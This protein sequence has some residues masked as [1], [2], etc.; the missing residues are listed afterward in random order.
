[1]SKRQVQPSRRLVSG[2]MLTVMVAIGAIPVTASAGV[3]F[4]WDPAGA[5]VPL[6]G[7]GSK[8]TANGIEGGHYLWSRQPQTTISPQTPYTVDFIEQITQ[9]TLNGVPVATPGLNGTPGAAG[10]YGL[11]LAMQAN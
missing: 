6:G 3:T 11:Y 1:M 4:T 8:F 2:I 10:S 7:A 5:S 9:F